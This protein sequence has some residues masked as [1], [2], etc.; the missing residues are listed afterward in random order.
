[1]KTKKKSKRI[2]KG[3][4]IKL[5]KKYRVNYKSLSNKKIAINL[6]DLR[7]EYMTK[8]EKLYILN[9]LPNNRNKKIMKENMNKIKNIPK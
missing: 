4:L 3:Y 5:A 2:S 7:Q 9:L 8:K 1:M 6:C